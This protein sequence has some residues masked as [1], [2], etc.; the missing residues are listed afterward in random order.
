MTE[1]YYDPLLLT[2]KAAALGAILGAVYDLFRVVRVAAKKP[3]APSG[4]VFQKI[5]LPPAL[6]R[7][8]ELKRQR[9]IA[10]GAVVFIEDIAFF[11][12]CAAAV[13]LFFLGENS[14][15]IRIYCLIFSFFGFLVYHLT[16]GRVVIYFSS[17][18]IFFAKCLL[19]WTVYIII[20]PIKR[21][22]RVVFRLSRAVFTATVG[23]II[24]IIRKKRSQALVKKLVA[25]AAECFGIF[26]EVKYDEKI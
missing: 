13:T 18:I 17:A 11:I 10:E 3:K 4:A 2:L 1:L 14:G 9:K 8:R 12:V 21:F 6:F 26:G 5:K 24:L 19:Y 16:L 22:L 25:D 7:A 23:K 20:V 15:K